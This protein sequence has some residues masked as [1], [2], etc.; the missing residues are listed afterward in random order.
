MNA[1]LVALDRLSRM[2]HHPSEHERRPLPPA[3]TTH[4]GIPGVPTARFWA[5]EWPKFSLE[6]MATL[7]DTDIQRNYPGT[8]GQPHYYLAISGGGPNGA[9]GVGLLD[10]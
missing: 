7:T 2:I 6:Q 10:D 4:A 3:L 5:D 1:I 9:F 8:Y